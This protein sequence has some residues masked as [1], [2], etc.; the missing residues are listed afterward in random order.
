MSKNLTVLSYNESLLRESDVD[1]LKGPYWLNDTIISFYF[2]YLETELFKGQSFLLFVSPEVT[3]C[4]KVSPQRE[5]R[6]FLDPLVSTARRDFIFFALNDNELTESS[7]GS[8]WSLLVFSRP[9]KMT[10][11]YDSSHGVNELQAVELAEKILRY[12]SLPVQGRFEQMPCLQQN[13]GYDCGV[14]VLCNTEQLASYAC[15]YGRIK[16]CPKLS[17]SA[18]MEKRW[19]ILDIIQRLKMKH[20]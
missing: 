4:I 10:F 15:H 3:Q 7:G 11:H 6:V 9:E 18:V 13:N 8:H 20:R 19:E 2:E 16:G 14:H 12:F 17:Y 5:L 1:L